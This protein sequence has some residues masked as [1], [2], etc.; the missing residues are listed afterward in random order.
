MFSNP[1]TLYIYRNEFSKYLQDKKHCNLQTRKIPFISRAY[2]K[3]IAFGGF[4]M[5][6]FN[7]NSSFGEK[8]K[9][10]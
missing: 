7:N 4:L 8:K 5:K 6:K 3:F 2:M 10:R 9:F 1:Y